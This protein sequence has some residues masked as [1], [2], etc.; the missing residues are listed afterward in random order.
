MIEAN[1]EVGVAARLI[2][3]DLEGRGK[4]ANREGRVP[5]VDAK[6]EDEPLVDNADAGRLFVAVRESKAM[7]KRFELAGGS[8]SRLTRYPG[9]T[10]PR[11]RLPALALAAATRDAIPGGAGNDQR[12]VKRPQ[13]K[14]CDI[15]AFELER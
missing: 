1:A 15:G 8:A 9:G 12:D 3:E 10:W 11:S 13:G 2:S 7:G 4:V 5:I 14:R 6:A